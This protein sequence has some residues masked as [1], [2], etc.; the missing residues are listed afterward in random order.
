[1]RFSYYYEKVKW[2]FN[3]NNIFIF[4]IWK[5]ILWL[6]LIYVANMCNDQKLSI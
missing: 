6:F 4:D 2:S 5:F 1:M 3:K